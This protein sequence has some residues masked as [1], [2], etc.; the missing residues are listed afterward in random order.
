L[1]PAVHGSALYEASHGTDA[2]LKVWEYLPFGPWSN[3]NEFESWLRYKAGSLDP[4]YYAVV[5]TSTSFAS[6]MVSFNH[7]HPDDG[8]IEIAGIWFSPSLQRT[9]AATEASFLMLSY[10]MDELGYRR[11]QWMCDALNERSRQAARRLGFRFEGISYNHMVMKGRNRD[12]AW[13]SM[14]DYEWPEVRTII[15]SWLDDGNFDDNDKAR[16]SLS[17]AMLNKR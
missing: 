10:A 6:G 1:N 12:T 15:E 14:L 17:A 5:P 8:V 2:A 11:M 16:S 3:L 13:Y 7:I 4:I 9:R